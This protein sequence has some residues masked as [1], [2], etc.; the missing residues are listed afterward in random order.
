MKKKG[1][2]S[3][4]F[5]PNDIYSYTDKVRLNIHEVIMKIKKNMLRKY[6][7][8]NTEKCFL[9]LIWFW[10]EKHKKYICVFCTV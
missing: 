6:I 2:F 8:K 4:F 3:L 1:S 10:S 7:L 5:F 9:H